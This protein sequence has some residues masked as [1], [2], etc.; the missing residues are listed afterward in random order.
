MQLPFPHRSCARLVLGLGF[1]QALKCPVITSTLRPMWTVSCSTGSPRHSMSH[2]V[3]I[4]PRPRRSVPDLGQ[5]IW[6]GHLADL[7]EIQR[8]LTGTGIRLVGSIR[9]TRRLPGDSRLAIPDSIRLNQPSDADVRAG[10][11]T[12]CGITSRRTAPQH[13]FETSKNESGRIERLLAVSLMKSGGP[14]KGGMT[15]CQTH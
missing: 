10:K 6:G 13:S 2:R 3:A 4:Q 9:A 8:R 11:E 12:T 15:R 14:R 7:V 5:S 1:G